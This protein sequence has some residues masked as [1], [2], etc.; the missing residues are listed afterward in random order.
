MKI[1]PMFEFG[2]AP[3]G[4]RLMVVRP[5]HPD[6]ALKLAETAQATNDQALF[7]KMI[8]A[9]TYVFRGYLGR[10][11]R[12]MNKGDVAIVS[13]EGLFLEEVQPGDSFITKMPDAEKAS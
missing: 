13:E 6:V 8:E 3:D 11:T 10:R 4:Q 1:K 12:G 5:K 9:D 7:Q 2:H